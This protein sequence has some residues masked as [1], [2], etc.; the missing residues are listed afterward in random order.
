MGPA[1][2]PPGG[3]LRG[4]AAEI[5]AIAFSPSGRRLATA[6]LD[7]TVVVWDA[8]RR[9]KWAV[10]TGHSDV[11]LGLDFSRDDR[12]LLS[13]GGDQTITAWDLDLRR[14][15]ATVSALR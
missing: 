12:T 14:A 6:G 1:P 4:H 13:S 15:A 8:A 11:V 9:S 7:R 2:P 10:L 5:R 3:R